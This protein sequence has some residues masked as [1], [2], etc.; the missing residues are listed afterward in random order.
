MWSF[1]PFHWKKKEPL[2]SQSN[3]PKH[4]YQ[5][6]SSNSY[7]DK[8]CGKT[9]VTLW[10][11]DISIGICEK[12]LMC[13]CV[14]LSSWKDLV[15]WINCLAVLVG[16]KEAYIN[17]WLKHQNA[18]LCCVLRNWIR[19][20]LHELLAETELTFTSDSRT[21]THTRGTMC[22]SPAQMFTDS[23]KS[24]LEFCGFQW[25]SVS[26]EVVYHSV[27]LKSFWQEGHWLV[28]LFKIP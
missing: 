6:L 17:T 10:W 9:S 12:N 18:W 7:A 13:C 16:K 25:T 4:S 19:P 3:H 15:C 23:M 2:P 22:Q 1:I 20:K 27:L 14:T 5:C 21:H 28:R 8:K 26:F 24:E 11:M